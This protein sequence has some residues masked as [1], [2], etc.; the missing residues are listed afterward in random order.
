MIT[1]K[2][3]TFQKLQINQRRSQYVLYFGWRDNCG[4]DKKCPQREKIPAF[5]DSEEWGNGKWGNE[6]W[7]NT[8]WGNEEWRNEE[9][10]RK[11]ERT[12]NGKWMDGEWG[13]F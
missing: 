3:K 2:G 7:G 9:W 8:E 4:S 11:N 5:K 12:G 10:G 1:E 6:E 13:I